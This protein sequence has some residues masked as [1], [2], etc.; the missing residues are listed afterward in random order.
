MKKILLF[1]YVFLTITISA[2][3]KKFFESGEV[4]LKNPVEKVNLNFEYELPLVKVEIDGKMYQFLFDTG[5]PTVISF[6]IFNQLKLKEKH[7]SKV[8]DSQKNKQKQIFTE[9]PEMKIDNI[10][11]KNIGTV[12]MDL[13]GTEFGCIKIDGIIGANQMAKL[14][15]R[16]NYSENNLEATQNLTN[17]SIEGYETVFS[18]DPKMQKTPVIEAKILDK[19]IEMTFDTGFTGSMKITDK[20]F[21]PKKGNMKFVETYGIASIGAFGAGK[22]QVSYHFKTDEIM[23]DQKKFSNQLIVTG[24]TS[25]LGNEFLKKFSYILDWKNSKIYLHQ[26]KEDEP[27]LES[28]GFGYRFIDN[29]AK[30]VLLFNDKDFPLKFDDEIL[31]I[32]DISL[33]NLTNEM[34]CT[35]MLNRIEK[36]SDTVNIKVKREGKVLNFVIA[37][38]EYLK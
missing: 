27:K 29:K 32:N 7:T 21:D 28:F 14:F 33:E 36:D 10:I 16:I 19:K 1:A 35:Y 11:F 15:W 34:V 38:K 2:Q 3:G 25:L 24:S 22:P 23:I 37:K 5:A 20:Y 17:F 6:A 4:V 8:S 13:Q 9:I 12:V 18:F 26:I 31:S 30:V